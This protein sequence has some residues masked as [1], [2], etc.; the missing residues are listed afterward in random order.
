MRIRRWALAVLMTGCAS[1][2][3]STVHEPTEPLR[4]TAV[5][6][7]PVRVLGAD[8]AGWRGYELGQRQIDVALRTVGDRLAMIGPAQ[9]KISR[10]DEPGWLGNTALP[11]LTHAAI[12]PGEA[13]LLRATVEQRIG[14]SIQEREDSKGAPKGGV[15]T[16][17]TQWLVTVELLHPASRQALAEL[18]GSVIIDPFAA[19]TGEEE[20]DPVWPMTRLLEKLTRE[21]LSLT[22]RWQV[23]RPG[24]RDSGLTL[25]LAPAFTAAWPD[26][27]DAQPDA[28][29]AEVWMQARARFLSP[30]LDEGS[31]ARL[32]RV[33]PC[34]L[35]VAA[36]G[37]ASLKPGDLILSIDGQPPLPEVLAR[38]RLTG[39]PVEVRVGRDG[40]ERDEVIP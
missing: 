21:A 38:K 4:V 24:T 6:V 20:F 8:G 17:E 31:A 15:V 13:L 5:V 18:S 7:P 11:V 1:G 28:L 9:V 32:A 12:P 23:D 22:R 19:P 3:T 30:W 10:W 37:N 25:A 2:F 40:N 35:V 39:V 33:P 27:R 36:P 34:M 29:Q 26:A 16:H 14:S